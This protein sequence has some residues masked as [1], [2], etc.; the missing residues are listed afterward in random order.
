MFDEKT[1]PVQLRDYRDSLLA[2]DNYQSELHG[3]LLEEDLGGAY[4]R[5]RTE[6]DVDPPDA[7]TQKFD[8][9]YLQVVKA[10]GLWRLGRWE[11]AAAAI[12]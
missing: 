3:D 7:T 10:N 4:N 12:S 11:D 2:R 8:I 6:W 5:L 9:A 1:M